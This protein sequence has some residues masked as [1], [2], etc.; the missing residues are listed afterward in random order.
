LRP[1]ITLA[2]RRLVEQRWAHPQRECEVFQEQR[3]PIRQAQAQQVADLLW[4][5]QPK[6]RACAF[7][8]L[9]VAAQPATREDTHSQAAAVLGAWLLDAVKALEMLLDLGPQDDRAASR[10]AFQPP[11]AHQ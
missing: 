7:G 9:I 4:V 6:L 3:Q 1:K 10:R 8:E 2:R 11:V 5:I